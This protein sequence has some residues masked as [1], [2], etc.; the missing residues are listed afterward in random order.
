LQ[1]PL[2]VTDSH[3]S[4]VLVQLRDRIMKGEFPPGERLAEVNLAALLG[5]SRTPVRLAL[6]TLEREGLVEPS[7]SVGYVMRR[8]TLKEILDAIDVRGHLEGMAARVLAEQGAPKPLLDQLHSCLRTGDALFAKEGPEVDYA[9]DYPA[10]AEMN[11]RLHEL[12]AKGCGNAALARAIEINNRLPF[13][14]ASATLPMQSASREGHRW[15]V[16]AH[17][18]HRSLVDAIERGQ[19]ARAQSIAE[20]HVQIAKLNMKLALEQPELL[21][22]LKLVATDGKA[23]A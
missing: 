4:R 23:T 17:L 21:P 22:A 9:V 8:F 2:R 13:A 7:G 1:Y 6:A 14:P 3:Q 20:E 19:G 15:M 18:Q 11:D 16:F 5:V 12:I 10:Y